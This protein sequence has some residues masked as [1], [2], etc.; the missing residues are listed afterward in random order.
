MIQRP[1]SAGTLAAAGGTAVAND[2]AL[3]SSSVSGG[4]SAFTRKR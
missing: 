2:P 1:S 4:A 3:F